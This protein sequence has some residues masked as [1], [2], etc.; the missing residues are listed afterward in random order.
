[1]LVARRADRLA[2]LKAT[3]EG[4]YGIEAHTVTMDVRDLAHVARLPEEL[5]EPFAEVDVLVNN[6]GLALGMEP[7]T[8]NDLEDVKTMVDT[9]VTS[10]IAFMTTFSKGMKARN[11]GH[12]ITM[13][14]IAGQAG[15]AG[16]SVYCATKFAVEGASEAARHDLVGTQ[17]RVTVIEPGAVETEFSVVRFHGDKS[18]ADAVY[19]G[20]HPLVAAD[21]ADNVIY[22]ATRPPQVQI[23]KMLVLATN[24]ASG[25]VKATPLLEKK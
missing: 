4:K 15:Y 9:N 24:Q 25:S 13:G 12:I 23:C 10:M 18:K 7:I 6:A 8:S 20:F 1:M 17:V 5:P 11:R 3:L 2:A 14:S 16:G 19:K 22:A 21:I